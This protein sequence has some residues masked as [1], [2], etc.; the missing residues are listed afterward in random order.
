MQIIVPDDFPMP[1]DGVVDPLARRVPRAP[2]RG[3]RTTRSTRRSPTA[4]VNKLNRIV[5]DSPEA[6][7]RHHHH[8]ARAISTCGRRSTTSAST[9]ATPP[10]SASAST[11][12][13]CP[14]RSSPTACA[15][16]PKG[17]E[18]ILVVEEKR[19]IIEY[20]LKEQLYNWRD[21]VRPRVV[22]K[23]DEKGEW[24]RPHG[25]WLLPAAGE[26]TPAMIAR[27]IA[28]RIA[29]PRPASARPIE[30]SRARRLDQREG[31]G[32]REAAHHA[33][34]HP[35]LLLGLP[36]QHV[37]QRARRQPRAG[38]HRLP[39]DGDLDG[40]R[41][42]DLHAH[43]RRRR[44]VDRPGAVHRRR[45][46]SSRTSATAPTTTRLLAIR[47]AVAAKVNIT[48]KILYNDAVA[49]TGGQ[50]VDGP[51][52]VP[53]DRA[54]GR[55]RG[56]EE[57]RRRHRRAGQVPGRLLRR[58]RRRPPPRRPRRA[59]SASC[60]RSQGVTV[61]I[62]DQTCA[63]E[64]RRRRKRGKFPD[65]AKRVV[66]NELV[67]EGCG[68]CGVQVELPVGRA[69]RD[70]VR[71][72]ARDRPVL[73]QQ[74]LLVRQGLLPELRHRRG[75]HS[76]ASRRR[77]RR[78]EFPDAARARRCRRSTEPYGILVT[79]IGGTGVVTIGAL[80]GMAAHLE[81]KGCSGA[82]HDRPRAE[83]RRGRLA[84]P[85]RRH[86]RGASTRRASPPARRSSCSAATS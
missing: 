41:D 77:P 66:I 15:S 78:G 26:L 51:L 65:P 12:S 72:Q 32:A 4:R 14:G 54:A 37:D 35:V 21:D 25:D 29:A 33:R 55:G 8:R 79:G 68:D 18:E 36:A 52:T 73:V 9:S 74:G 61:L 83:E 71:P 56:R 82:R 76:C 59:C 31:S 5:I 27:V 70:R 23:F 53:H 46:T 86:A 40:P 7:P 48:Y 11:R 81:G 28:Q 64:K 16:S 85:H 69:G 38:R 44:A 49:M 60:A 84:R 57:D 22:G 24:V 39:R 1:P 2:K 62:Y 75:R 45:S 20:Q 43:G 63:A 42:D 3:C 34:A 19:Q 30:S 47:A 67:C 6:A 58:R 13:R 10:R 50:P 17:L 80:L